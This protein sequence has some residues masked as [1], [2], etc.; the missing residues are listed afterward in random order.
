MQLVALKFFVAVADYSTA[1]MARR[2]PLVTEYQKV[3]AAPGN[4]S[5]SRTLRLSA[6]F[7]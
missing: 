1:E 5:R 6:D 2:V 3:P 4:P 7:P